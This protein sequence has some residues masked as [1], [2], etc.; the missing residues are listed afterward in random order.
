[1]A[2]DS[3]MEDSRIGGG[4]FFRAALWIAWKKIQVLVRSHL[5]HILAVLLGVLVLIR[6]LQE[7][8]DMVHT[9]HIGWWQILILGITLGTIAAA[10]WELEVFGSKLSTSPQE[11][12]FV[13][14]M[15]SL[16]QELE[17]FTYGKD[18]DLNLDTRLNDF[19]KPFLKVTSI[20]LCGKKEIDAALMLPTESKKEVEL[21]LKTDGALYPDELVIPLPESEEATTG[22]AGYAYQLLKIVYMPLKRWRLGWPFRYDTQCYEPS[23]PKRGWIEVEKAYENFR[24]VLCIP[25]AV[26]QERNRR[27]PFGVLN[28]STKSL[29]PFVPRDFMMGE[30]FSSI[31]AMAFAA[32]QREAGETQ[33]TKN[34]QQSP[35]SPEPRS[36]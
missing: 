22:P 14:A 19:I 1:M 23:E 20:T 24:S 21:R 2:E 16:L 3:E 9:R 4:I 5:S 26:Y 29:D 32:I 12:R 13:R 28:Y 17:R 8:V 34:P 6:E 7:L 35:H 27:Q 15:R 30:C 33:N 25:V 31:L 36:E 18:R 11:V 10:L